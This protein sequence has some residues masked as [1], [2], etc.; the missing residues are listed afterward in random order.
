MLEFCCMNTADA[1]RLITNEILL[2]NHLE[3]VTLLQSE[4]VDGPCI[5][6]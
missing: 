5:D 2:V 1:N 3:P 4:E 6:L